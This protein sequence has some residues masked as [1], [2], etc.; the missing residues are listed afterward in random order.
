MEQTPKPMESTKPKNRT[1][2]LAIIIIVILIVVGVGVYILTRPTSPPPPTGPQ[3]A[4]NDDGG[5]GPTD[6]ACLF[7]PTSINA[8][9]SG[10][11]VVWTNKGTIGHT[12]TTCDASNS[13]PSG[14]CPNMDAAGLDS[15]NSPTIAGGGATYSHMFTKAGTY[16]YY[17]AIHPSTMHG[18]VVVS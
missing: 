17:C 7:N 11:A 16:Y 1:M 8:N 9:V 15:F 14:A 18:K 2:V 5:C 10:A 3:V 4:I 13:P 12:V 6:T